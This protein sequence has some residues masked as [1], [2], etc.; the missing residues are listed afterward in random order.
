MVSLISQSRVPNVPPERLSIQVR[1]ALF[2]FIA[3]RSQIK[4][5]LTF[6][7]YKRITAK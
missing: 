2:L 1:G 4:Q 7:V 5:N 6:K 3:S